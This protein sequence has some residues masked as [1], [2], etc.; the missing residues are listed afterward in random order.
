MVRR[1]RP[2]VRLVGRLD[3]KTFDPRFITF[4]AMIALSFL[5]ASVLKLAYE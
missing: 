4:G 2:R 5:G 1:E 3:A